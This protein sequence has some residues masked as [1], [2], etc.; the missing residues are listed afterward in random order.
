MIELPVT[1]K[2]KMIDVRFDGVKGALKDN[3]QLVITVP[4]S[5]VTLFDRG[6]GE[7]EIRVRGDQ[8]GK[9]FLSACSGFWRVLLEQD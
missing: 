7:V 3:F 2:G 9:D 8:Q 6:D 4:E 5:S 1:I